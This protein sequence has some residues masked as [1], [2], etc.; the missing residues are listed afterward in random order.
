MFLGKMAKL[1]KGKRQQEIENGTKS[2]GSTNPKSKVYTILVF[3]F[4]F[5][6][7][8]KDVEY[9]YVLLIFQSKTCIIL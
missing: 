4:P 2:S 3:H 6:L 8:Y 5:I 9:N 1:F 7:S